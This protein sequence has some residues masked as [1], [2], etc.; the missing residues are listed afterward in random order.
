MDYWDDRRG[1]KWLFLTLV[2]FGVYLA[3]FNFDLG[4]A[5]NY[6][7]TQAGGLLQFLGL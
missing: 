7:L 6:T 1:A 2:V 5:Y 4:A 3:F